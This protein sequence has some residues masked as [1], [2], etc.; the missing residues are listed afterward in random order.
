MEELEGGLRVVWVV[1]WG[2]VKLVVWVRLGEELR[3]LCWVERAL[4]SVE[5]KR[6]KRLGFSVG[7]GGILALSRLWILSLSG[8]QKAEEGGVELRLLSAGKEWSAGRIQI[9]TGTGCCCWQRRT[10]EAM[11]N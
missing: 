9:S 8:S 11:G 7:R 10:A 6:K 1:D 5:R 3:E 2:V 4:A